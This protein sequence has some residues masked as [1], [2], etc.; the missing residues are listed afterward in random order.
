MGI[1]FVKPTHELIEEIAVNMRQADVDEVWVSNHFTPIEALLDGFE[2]SDF[3][4]VV[5]INNSPCVILGLVIRDVL[6]GS[7]TPWLLGTDYAL[8][9]KREFIKLVPDVISDMLNVCPYLVNHVHAE[10]RVSIR[11]LKRIGF[12]IEQP[13][14]Y[15]VDGELFHRFHLKRGS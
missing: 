1:E 10:N 2:E 12:T 14:P 11:W 8:K 15:G 13:L 4:V 9:H 5:T 6:S 7:G 3:C